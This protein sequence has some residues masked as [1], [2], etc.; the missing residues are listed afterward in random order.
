MS[1]HEVDGTVWVV[2]EDHDDGLGYAGV[3][4]RCQD[5]PWSPRPP[6]PSALTERKRDAAVLAVLRDEPD[7]GTHPPATGLAFAQPEQLP[8]ARPAGPDRG[9]RECT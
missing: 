6:L 5:T 3:R 9:R 8:A 4:V 2:D 1:L 7:R